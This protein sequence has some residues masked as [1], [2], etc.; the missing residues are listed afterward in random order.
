MKNVISYAIVVNGKKFSGA[1]KIKDGVSIDTGLY[2]VLQLLKSKI[3]N[4]V[5]ELEEVDER[6]M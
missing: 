4:M 6:V 1:Y 2:I 5:K 3:P